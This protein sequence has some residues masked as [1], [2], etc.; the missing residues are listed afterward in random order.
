MKMK[1]TN[2]IKFIIHNSNI[3]EDQDVVQIYNNN[4]LHDQISE[5]VMYHYL[6]SHWTVGYTKKHY[7]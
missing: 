2:K 1:K 7:K 3:G 4:F 6:E 5:D